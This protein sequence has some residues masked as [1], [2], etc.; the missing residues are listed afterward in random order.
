MLAR[1]SQNRDLVGDME[2]AGRCS[3][4]GKR[5]EAGGTMCGQLGFLAGRQAGRPNYA[6][7]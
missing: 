2:R 3:R 5:M 6:R 4:V 1:L 7:S